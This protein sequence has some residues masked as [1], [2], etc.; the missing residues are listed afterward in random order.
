MQTPAMKHWNEYFESYS[1]VNLPTGI[2]AGI[3]GL[4]VPDTY[5]AIPD[6]WK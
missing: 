2:I 1:K 5:N 3:I 4:S 6:I